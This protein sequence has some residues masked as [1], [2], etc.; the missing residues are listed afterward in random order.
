MDFMNFENFTYLLYKNNMKIYYV[1]C[2]LDTRKPGNFTYGD[3]NFNYEPFY[4]GKGK[5]NRCIVHLKECY[6]K[7][8]FFKRKINKIIKTTGDAPI[9]IKIEENL[10]EDCAFELEKKL[11][12]LIGRHDLGL[13]TLVNMTDGGEG[14][15]N[16]SEFTKE[17]LR[18]S[19]S[20]ERCLNISKSK[21]G[22]KVSKKIKDLLLKH[23]KVCII[24]L[25]KNLNIIKEYDSIKEA[26]IE[27]N[28]TNA[29]IFRCC[30]KYYNI[31]NGN[32]F[33]YK[34]DLKG[35]SI[36]I[37]NKENDGNWKFLQDSRKK[38]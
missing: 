7:N 19:F 38:R 14:L 11:I 9:I 24:Y 34:S 15:T 35:I 16:C 10:E 6:N 4:I 1:Y 29:N 12:K 20:K 28:I 17:K 30:K 37:N 23:S 13:G 8:I 25:D 18:I 31:R 26:C 33:R 36:Y 32:T 21:K 5:K 3:F 27:L 2:Y 22:K